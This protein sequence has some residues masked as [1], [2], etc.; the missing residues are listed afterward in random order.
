MYM[1]CAKTRNPNAQRS[2]FC[3]QEFWTICVH[4]H[5]TFL[6]DVLQGAA[7]KVKRQPISCWL[8]FSVPTAMSAYVSIPALQQLTTN[9]VMGSIMK[10]SQ[11]P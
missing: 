5:N 6:L 4:A 8:P 11:L 3:C 10:T 1:V 7:A 9:K 2:G